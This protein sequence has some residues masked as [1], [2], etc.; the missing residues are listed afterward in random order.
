MHR[1]QLQFVRQTFNLYIHIS[2]SR[3]QLRDCN[4]NIPFFV[5]A[6]TDL[7][8][9]VLPADIIC[10]VTSCLVPLFETYDCES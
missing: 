10:Y 8:F 2:N 3:L 6:M 5:P 4:G 1:A 7:V 9:I